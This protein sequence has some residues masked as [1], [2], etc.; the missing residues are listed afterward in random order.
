[1]PKPELK[2]KRKHIIFDALS[3]MY[4]KPNKYCLKKW[5]TW[6]EDIFNNTF[7]TSKCSEIIRKY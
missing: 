6:K 2:N 3:I 4:P 5:V 7:E 1:M